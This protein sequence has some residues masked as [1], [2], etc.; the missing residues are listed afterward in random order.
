MHLYIGINYEDSLYRVAIVDSTTSPVFF[1]SNGNLNTLLKNEEIDS[2]T[3]LYV[4][5]S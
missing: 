2:R 5:G 3:V 4:G 1:E